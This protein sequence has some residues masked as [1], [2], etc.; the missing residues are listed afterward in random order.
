MSELATGVPG[1]LVTIHMHTKGMEEENGLPY[2]AFDS[3]AILILPIPIDML[4]HPFEG[5]FQPFF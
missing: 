3:Q 2:S 4:P 1:L 5:A